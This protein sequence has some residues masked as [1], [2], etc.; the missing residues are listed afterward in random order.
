MPQSP[1]GIILKTE[2][3][4]FNKK[5]ENASIYDLNYKNGVQD[6]RNKY[7]DKWNLN[8]RTIW[9]ACYYYNGNIDYK[10]RF[11]AGLKYTHIY[12][13]NNNDLFRLDKYAEYGGASNVG[14]GYLP[15]T[16]DSLQRAID[17]DNSFRSHINKDRYEL[18][19]N[20]P[21]IKLPIFGLHAFLSPGVN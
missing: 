6:F 7:N 9:D 16:R 11:S 12:D 10:Y 20:T 21:S 17:A 3:R 4:Y 15:S 8:L 5:N 18:T 13:K 2:N 14:V 1:D 19:G